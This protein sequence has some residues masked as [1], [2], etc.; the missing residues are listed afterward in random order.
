MQINTRLHPYIPTDSAMLQE[1]TL[2]YAETS[3]IIQSS[4]DSH[5]GMPMPFIDRWPPRR[6][7]PDLQHVL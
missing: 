5:A 3:L 1:R 2:A 7:H 4:A 6:F